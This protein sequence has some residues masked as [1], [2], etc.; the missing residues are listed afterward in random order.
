MVVGERD[1][2]TRLW[3][4]AWQ[5]FPFVR[6]SRTVSGVF[7]SY[8]AMYPFLLLRIFACLDQQENHSV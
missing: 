2:V 4:F 3:M 6:L 5:S 8:F 7:S 1:F